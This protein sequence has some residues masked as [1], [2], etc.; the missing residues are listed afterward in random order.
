MF[1]RRKTFLDD[2]ARIIFWLRYAAFMVDYIMLFLI[3]H[4]SKPNASLFNQGILI[5]ISIP[6][7]ITYF[8]LATILEST[9]LQATPAKYFFRLK[10]CKTNGSRITFS[11]SLF[12]NIFKVVSLASLIG[13]WLINLT[14]R[15]QALH[16]LVVGSI[17]TKR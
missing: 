10:V 8:I 13:A 15:R 7:L 14:N 2:G 17:V 6:A 16:D 9:R 11:E 12:R 3:Y 5:T 1:K 4:F